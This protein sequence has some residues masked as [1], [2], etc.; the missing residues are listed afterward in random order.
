[1]RTRPTAYMLVAFLF[2][3]LASSASAQS[4]DPFFTTFSAYYDLVYHELNDTSNLGAH[5]ESRRPSSAASHSSHSSRKSA[6]IISTMRTCRHSWWVH[7]CAWR[8]R[9]HECCRTSS[10][11]GLYHC[12][13][14]DITDFAISG[15]GGVD[16]KLARNNN[17]RIRT[18][19]DVRHMFDDV[20]SFNAVRFSLG[21]VLPLNK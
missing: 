16:F 20:E 8:M 7:G 11:A 12:G 6:S 9:A 13:A 17:V 18:Q 4:R 15:G 5:F 2:S 14:C 1:M 19:V 10:Y 3:V 21:V